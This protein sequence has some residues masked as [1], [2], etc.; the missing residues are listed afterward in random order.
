MD[1]DSSIVQVMEL[2]RESLC[3]LKVLWGNAWASQCEN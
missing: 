1:T 3:A 2:E